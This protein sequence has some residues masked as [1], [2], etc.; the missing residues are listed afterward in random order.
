SQMATR[1]IAAS[2]DSSDGAIEEGLRV[3]GQTLHYERTA[4]FLFDDKRERLELRHEWCAEGVES[5]RPGMTGLSIAEFGWPLDQI[6][7][8]KVVHM[9]RRTLPATAK[10]ARQVLDR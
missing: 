3:V 10:A 2:V 6:A 7:A 1:F 8:G 5:F 4:V 9:D